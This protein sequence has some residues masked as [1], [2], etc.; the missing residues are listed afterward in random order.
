M[1]F[2][3]DFLFIYVWWCVH[4]YVQMFTPACSWKPDAL[5]YGLST[6]PLKHDLSLNLGLIFLARL[7]TTKLQGL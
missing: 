1:S 3:K 2:L 5:L 7:E 4:I 6:I